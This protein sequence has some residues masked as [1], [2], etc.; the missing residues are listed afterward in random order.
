MSNTAEKASLQHT[1]EAFLRWYQGGNPDL[2]SLEAMQDFIGS[3]ISI[4]ELQ[5][6][7][8][9]LR[10]SK[11]F[12]SAQQPLI[13]KWQA[14]LATPEGLT[15]DEAYNLI[16]ELFEGFDHAFL[17]ERGIRASSTRVRRGSISA[18]KTNITEMPCWTLHM[19]LKGSALFLND[20]IEC[21]VVAGDLLLLRPDATYHYGL[22][23]RADFWEH[24]WVLFQPRPHWAELLEWQDLGSGLLQLSL[25]TRENR[26]HMEGL[27]RELIALGDQQEPLYA[28][29][30]YNKLEELL[31]RARSCTIDDTKTPV[32]A[33]IVT[34]CEYMQRHLAAQFSVQDVAA[35]CNLST[36]RLAHLFKEQ[37][38][39]GPKAWINDARLQQARKL[40]L[41][42][43]DSVGQIGRRVG[44]ED[45]AHFTRYFKQSMGCSPRQFR[46]T[47]GGNRAT[48]AQP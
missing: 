3:P 40:L 12:L 31:I 18:S 9:R 48:D 1:A 6:L 36:S 44:Y 34:A 8:Q 21:Q 33:R 23:P 11:A 4:E 16:Q 2:Q 46:Q 29:L 10:D 20:Q 43:R 13:S 41:N 22:H 27:F 28:D 47:F 5:H 45:P 30:Q 14:R 35:A 24:L 7:G 38:G 19:T 15:E 39:L 32:D 26:R 42:S 17:Y 25:P 37:M